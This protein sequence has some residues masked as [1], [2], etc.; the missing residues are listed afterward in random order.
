MSSAACAP[1][2]FAGWSALR[3]GNQ[4]HLR[5]AY[6]RV[7][8]LRPFRPRPPLVDPR[9]LVLDHEAR[10]DARELVVGALLRA[11]LDARVAGEHVD[12]LLALPIAS[13]DRVEG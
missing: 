11:G 7:D 12:E 4:T 3:D 1:R 10:R 8:P 13:F 2:Q 6:W 9:P 5:P